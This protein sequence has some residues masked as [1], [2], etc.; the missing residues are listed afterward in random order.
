MLI[1]EKKIAKEY[2]DRFAGERGG[3]KGELINVKKIK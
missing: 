2:Q 1:R 3:A